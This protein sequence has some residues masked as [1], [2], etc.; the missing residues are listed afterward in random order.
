MTVW[1]YTAVPLRPEGGTS[2]RSGELAAETP[3]ELRASLRRIGLQVLD[4]RPV[5]SSQRPREQG[6]GWLTELRAA[7]R[8]RVEAHL[9]GRR[10]DQRAE[11]YDGLATMLASGL[12]LLEAVDT[13]ITATKRRRSALR[14]MLVQVR[15]ALRSGSSLGDAM[16][17]HPTWFDASEVATV[18]AGQHSGMLA[19][20][21]RSLSERH[22]RS[23]EL[24]HRLIGA[25]AY[26]FVVSLVGIGVVIFLSV[27]TLPQLVGVLVDSGIE[28]PALTEHVMAVGRG[29][30]SYGLLGAGAVVVVAIPLGALVRT[31]IRRGMRPPAALRRLSPRVMR[32]MAVSRFASQL[33]QMLR[34]GVPMVEA[35]RVLAPTSGG[36]AFERQLRTAADRVERGAELS[37]ALDDEHWFDAEFRRLL[38]IGQASGELDDLLE[39]LG[40]RYARQARRLIDRLT[41]ILE[42]AVILTLAVLVGIVVMAAVLPLLR[43]QE[44]L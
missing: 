23:A 43:L 34:T 17:T 13:L 42:P 39:R 11:L 30:A 5:R 16:G 18:R 2:P 4:V 19:E 31:A 37:E 44:I 1:R 26:P 38:D 24:A 6:A 40:E 22:Q 29:L 25:L 33:S 20:V 10:R 28:P 36:A 15:E 9:R 14:W 8:E 35:L 7:V 32:R 12:P 41:A 27:K 3:A 21:L